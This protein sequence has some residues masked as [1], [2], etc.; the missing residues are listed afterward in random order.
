MARRP[1]LDLPECPIHI[2]QR[3]NNRLPCFFHDEDYGAYREALGF[4]SR[5]CEVAIHAYVLMTNHVHLLC[6][7]GRKGDASRMMQSVGR[8][9]VRYVNGVYRRSGTLW[10]GRFKS[11][12]VDTERYLLT[13]YRYIEFNPLRA[14]MVA[15]PEDYSWSSY[16]FNALG[17]SDPLVDPHPL[18]KSLGASHGERAQA[19]RS[20]CEA[21]VSN[22][23]LTAIRA[24][25]EQ[26]RVLGST[27]FQ[28]E[29][30]ETLARCVRIR[31]PGRPPQEKASGKGVREHF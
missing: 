16:R 8:R 10:E 9:Y 14:K 11:C 2:V 5:A 23:E 20:L 1:R 13:C 27:R 6:T 22:E 28:A 12:I 4:A 17:Q 29:I 24:H 19:Y 25:L 18:Y 7:T 3:G 30:E 31:R 15:S 26:E 21:S